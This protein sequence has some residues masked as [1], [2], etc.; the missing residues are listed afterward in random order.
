SSSSIGSGL[1]IT[2]SLQFRPVVKGVKNGV[3]T[4]RC[5]DPKDS[6]KLITL[7]GFAYAVNEVHV[8]SVSARSGHQAWLTLSVNNMEQFSALQCEIHLPSTMKY[9]YGSAAFVGRNV[10]HSISVDTISGNILEV[11]C[12]SPTNAPFQ[13]S[14]GDIATMEFEVDGQGGTYALP[15]SQAIIADSTGK[16]ILSASYEGQLRIAAPQIQLTTSTL[17]L[18]SVSI[19]DTA[20]AA[21]QIGNVGDDTL[22]V[23]TATLPDPS[24]AIETALPLCVPPASSEL[25]NIRF[26]NGTRGT[27][28]T[29]MTLVHNDVSCNPSHVTTTALTFIP[30]T[31]R[32]V[33]TVGSPLDTVSVSLSL[34]NG[35]PITALQCDLHLPAG[36]VFIPGSLVTS[37]RSSTHSLSSS[38][39]SNGALRVIMFSLTQATFTGSTG[40][41]A[42]F[43]MVLPATEGSTVISTDNVII[44][45][46]SNQNVVS[47]TTNGNVDTYFATAKGSCC[48]SVGNASGSFLA[49]TDLH[50]VADVT[51]SA[52]VDASYFLRSP[53]SSSLPSGI[54]AVSAYFWN[55]TDKGVAFTNGKLD[56]SLSGLA[57]VSNS[58]SLVWLK[59]EN[60]DEAWTNLGG[61]VIGGRLESVEPFS[62]FSEFAIGSTTSDNP[63][64]VEISN[65]TVAHEK[66]IV[67]LS[68]TTS[69]ELENSGFEI[70]RKLVAGQQVL[71]AS[72]S[73][74]E[75]SEWRQ[76]GFLQGNG[77]S[78]SPH[79][80]LFKDAVSPGEYSYRLKQID[81]DG[82]I[83][84]ENQVEATVLLEEGDYGLKQN[85]PNPFNPATTF[86]FALK[87]AGQ[88]DLSIYN[89][90]GQK[91]RT[92]FNGAAKGEIVYSL[93]F[94]A[95]E[96]ASG[97]YFYV[98]R[99]N[100]TYEVKKFLLLK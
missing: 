83:G 89:S 81:R 98:L 62:S 57:G 71:G 31:L 76:V 11:V 93:S 30:N 7:H 46:T 9:V 35:E 90:L 92:L 33:S 91:V 19:F 38:V 50:L 4:L 84:Y 63:L 34:D 28:S 61:T 66:G 59:R 16:N 2:R 37:S 21:L 97:T 69:T 39:L 74:D 44:S 3:M 52:E 79:N 87:S 95:K 56:V 49:P 47:S 14:S 18:G 80:Y 10:D 65:L 36:A 78:N 15:V 99:A 45:N 96:L 53:R 67:V 60:P 51:T 86:E 55:F 77:T 26:H 40:E 82:T 1:L 70:D 73:V 64:P 23:S 41:V 54:Q 48:L 5:N 6:V 72:G 17:S 88:V 27:F 22:K 42:R 58:S 25:L 12:F 13:G 8:G 20:R 32:I 94:D 29:P 85:Y 68:W 24:Y 100:D 75:N 43:Q